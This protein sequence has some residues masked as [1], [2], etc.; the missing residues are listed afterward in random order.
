MFSINLMVTAKQEP[1]IDTQQIKR[2]E[3]RHNTTENHQITKKDS[4]RGK[5]EQSIH[6]IPKK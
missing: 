6:K 2:N 1:I 5:K 4:K 3:S